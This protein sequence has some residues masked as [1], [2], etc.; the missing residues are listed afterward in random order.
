MAIVIDTLAGTAISNLLKAVASL[1]KE[2]VDLIRNAKDDLKRLNRK[3]KRLQKALEAADCKPFLSNERDRDLE[4]ELKD[5]IYD[6]ED[7]IEEYQTMVDLSKREKDSMT[8]LNKVRK[9]W[10]TLCS[11][12]KEHVSTS[13]QL[14]NEI[15]EVN[16]RLEEI[17]NDSRKIED[18][19]NRTRKVSSGGEGPIRDERNNHRE[20]THHI[21]TTQPPIGRGNDKD[22]VK[23]FLFDGFTQNSVLGRHGQGGIGKTTLAKMVFKEVEQQ[24]G[25]RRWWVCVS[26]KPYRMGLL[27]KIVKEVCKGSEREPEGTTS[28]NDLCTRLQSEVSKSKFL[29]VLDDVW[30]LGW[31]RGEVEDAL[32]GGA[33]GSKILVTSRK[34]E[35]SQGIGAKMYILPGMTFEE[36]WSL[37]LDGAQKEENE[38]VSYNLKGIGERI[39]AK[40]GGLPLV[41]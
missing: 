31:W 18:L 1:L 32:M 15:K 28:L 9:P 30:E 38:L 23:K 7:I 12:F 4:I 34:V 19:L 6:A 27:Q 24:F 3:L 5:I 16:R 37:F 25:E 29:L 41:V 26:E 17:E 21:S 33:K 2:K 39:V 10:I 11:C 20:T 22:R 13:Y 35:V 14:G 8:S 40:C 36:S